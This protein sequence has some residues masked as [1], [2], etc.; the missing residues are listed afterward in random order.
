MLIFFVFVGLCWERGWGV[1]DGWISCFLHNDELD[2][3][4][5]LANDLQI[6]S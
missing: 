3:C 4:L 1:E 2:V 6:L 5:L